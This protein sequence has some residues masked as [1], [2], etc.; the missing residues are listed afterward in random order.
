MPEGI[1]DSGGRRVHAVMPAR[2]NQSYCRSRWASSV[3]AKHRERETSRGVARG[4]AGCDSSRPGRRS[5]RCR[6][7]VAKPSARR[8]T[9]RRVLIGRRCSRSGKP[10]VFTDRR[11]KRSRRDSRGSSANAERRLGSPRG[12]RDLEWVVRREH[13]EVGST[14]RGQG[15]NASFLVMQPTPAGQV[16]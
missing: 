1:R 4:L 14:P 3:L 5:T 7:V 11:W 8:N 13:P 12:S 6:A 10:A 15:G 2:R 9:P 16:S